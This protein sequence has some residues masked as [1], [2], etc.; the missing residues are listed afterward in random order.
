VT[1]DPSWRQGLAWSSWHRQH[2]ATATYSHDQ[3]RLMP[4]AA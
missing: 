4:S 1:Q 2:Q 3:R